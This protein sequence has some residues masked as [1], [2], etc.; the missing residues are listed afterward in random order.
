MDRSC[1]FTL[2]GC[3]LFILFNKEGAAEQIYRNSRIIT[4]SKRRAHCISSQFSLQTF[5][6]KIEDREHQKRLNKRLVHA[7]IGRYS[8][9]FSLPLHTTLGLQHYKVLTFSH[10]SLTQVEPY[11]AKNQIYNTISRQVH[12]DSNQP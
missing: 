4:L 9:S 11:N 7:V 2:I 1:T 3:H 12:R 5:W 6:D 10:L 8:T